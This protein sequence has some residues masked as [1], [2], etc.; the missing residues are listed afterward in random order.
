MSRPFGCE[1]EQFPSFQVKEDEF[2]HWVSNVGALLSYARLL[3]RL[4]R[5]C[6]L[7]VLC[8]FFLY[9]NLFFCSFFV[10]CLNKDCPDPLVVNVNILAFRLRRMSFGIEFSALKAEEYE[11]LMHWVKFVWNISMTCKLIT[12]VLI[13]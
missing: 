10:T 4:H 12:S 1:C 3:L 6:C 8:F 7:L 2:W 5:C 11:L 13:F 9:F